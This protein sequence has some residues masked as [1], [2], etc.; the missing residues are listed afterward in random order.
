[1]IVPRSGGLGNV[2]LLHPFPFLTWDGTVM[3]IA[4]AGSRLMSATLQGKKRPLVP[5][6][7]WERR[8][9]LVGL[10][11][12]AI[13]FG[14]ARMAYGMLLP[15]VR[16]SFSLSG[17]AAGSIAAASFAAFGLALVSATLLTRALG[18][19]LPVVIGGMCALLGAVLVA[20]AASVPM[21]VAGVVIAAASAGLCW[22]P[23]NAVAGRLVRHRRR[24]GVLSI[25][26]TGTTLGTALMALG[27]LLLAWTG[28][29][30]RLVWFATALAGG[31]TIVLAYA[32]LPPSH[33]LVPRHPPDVPTLDRHELL[34]R[35]GKRHAWPFYGFALAFGAVSAVFAT[36]AVDHVAGTASSNTLVV[37]GLLFLA[38][39]LL[40]GVG[41]LADAIERRL[42][43]S[44]AIVACFAAASIGAG[45][46]A[47]FPG[48]WTL[49]MA[50][51]GLSG[52]SVMV[53][54][55]LLSIGG[56]RLFPALPVA[57]FTLAVVAMSAGSV[58]G[59]AVAGAIADT[60]GTSAALAAA[61]IIAAVTAAV[62]VP[63]RV[64]A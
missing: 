64:D 9:T 19:K 33:R 5:L 8:T 24:D 35:L 3:G 31:V 17:S 57:G 12:T 55:V 54:S 27:A 45:T 20:V 44:G 34:R 63:L 56:L 32:L 11:A 51:S 7:A 2:P 29:D 22:T 40:G 37:G 48:S 46:L 21:L 15:S 42:T 26:S 52:A 49:V 39:G 1:M 28:A 61:A 62:A 13:A 41:F 47:L 10:V 23:F 36:F 30:W 38:Y 53:F 4:G 50:G 60:V 18:A 14:P 25:V 16:E 6:I 58:V 43:L 59:P